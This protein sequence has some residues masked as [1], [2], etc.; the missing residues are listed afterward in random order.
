MEN[1]FVV[2]PLNAS[3]FPDGANKQQLNLGQPSNLHS[4]LF[5]QVD[6]NTCNGSVI[7]L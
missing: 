3:G 7:S 1:L 4:V 5:S 6:E 2:W